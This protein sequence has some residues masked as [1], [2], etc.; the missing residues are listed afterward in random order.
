MAV[1]LELASAYIQITRK[2]F[3]EAKKDVAALKAAFLDAAKGQDAL[4]KPVKIKAPIVPGIKVPTP[5]A[6]PVATSGLQTALAKIGTIKTGIASAFDTATATPFFQS[7][8]NGTKSAVSALGSVKNAVGNAL[9]K[10]TDIPVLKQLK[11]GIAYVNTAFDD[12]LTKRYGK[13]AKPIKFSGMALDA[14][15]TLGMGMPVPGMSIAGTLPAMGLAEGHKQVTDYMARRKGRQERGEAP[16]LM[17]KGVNLAGAAVGGLVAKVKSIPLAPVIG[18]LKAVGSAALSGFGAAASSVGNFLGKLNGETL[19]A[20]G[21]KIKEV[22]TAASNSIN[23]VG[24]VATRGFAILTGGIGA[25]VRMADPVGWLYFTA[26]IQGVSI[27]IGRI[28]VPLLR[29]VTRYLIDLEHVLRSLTDAQRE[30]IL[31]WAK[32]ALVVLGSVMA[33]SQLFGMLSSGFSIMSGFVT[34]LTALGASGPVGWIIAIAGAIAALIAVV[35]IASGGM[36]GLF[37]GIRPALDALLNA[38]QTCFAAIQPIIQQG[39]QFMTAAINIGL[40]TIIPFITQFV[41]LLASTIG[42]LAGILQPIISAV[43]GSLLALYQQVQPVIQSILTGLMGLFQAVFGVMTRMYAAVAPIIGSILQAIIP[44]FGQIYT[45][46]YGLIA[47]LLPIIST[48]VT[49]IGSVLVPVFTVI[50]GAIKTIID[51]LVPVFSAFLAV[52]EPIFNAVVDIFGSIVEALEPL[53]GAFTEGTGIFETLLGVVLNAVLIPLRIFGWLLSLLVP[54]ISFF[55]SVIVGIVQIITAVLRPAFQFLADCIQ[56]INVAFRAIINGIIDALNAVLEYIPGTDYIARIGSGEGSAP[57]MP[58]APT[59]PAAPA[60]AG[61]GNSFVGQVHQKSELV[62]IADMWRKA[63]TADIMDPN[64]ALLQQQV[65][66]GD[67][68]NNLLT[69]IRNLLGSNST[70]TPAPAVGN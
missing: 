19:S 40:R 44:L 7:I 29:Q 52:L 8:A 23:Q 28:F 25:A 59:A 12:F 11:T 31:K 47:R 15:M 22:A 17:D 14:G 58:A 35:A 18:G 16:T 41:G 57:A 1:P 65:G 63:Q 45:F 68:Q 70:T 38:F 27:Q 34:V 4:N 32:I 9:G 60:A 55:A 61:G 49:A 24:S 51:A 6:V 42:R 3:D 66:Q 67:T 13:L 39:M 43:L 20:F 26:A 50:Y 10:A 33:F 69:Q 46:F 64:T 2:G 5:V 36:G 21:S 53:F 37:S 56:A 54:V 30:S 48:L 62:G